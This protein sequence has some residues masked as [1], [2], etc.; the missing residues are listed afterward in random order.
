MKL[1]YIKKQLKTKSFSQIIGKVIRVIGGTFFS[2][3]ECE[4]LKFTEL[5]MDTSVLERFKVDLRVISPDE[6]NLLSDR[7]HYSKKIWGDHWRQGA[8]LLGAVWNEKIVEY[9]W[10][11]SDG[12]YRDIF[13]GFYIKLNPGECYLFDYRALK[14]KPED[15]RHY[16]TMKGLVQFVF[17]LMKNRIPNRKNVC[18]AVVTKVNQKSLFFF[19]KHFNAE[20]VADV[21]LYRSLFWKWSRQK[22][23]V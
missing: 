23:A 14:G 6:I 15:L 20:L 9:C 19:K 5:P 10:I 11:I 22:K 3:T 18:Y 17:H 12:S 4:L 2:R 1:D 8:Q 21:T 7:E 16:R 13:D